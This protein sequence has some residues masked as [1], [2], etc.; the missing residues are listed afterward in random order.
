M[1]TVKEN[2]CCQEV[3]KIIEEIQEEMKLTDVKEIK[4]ITQHPGFASVCL[5]RHVL[6]TAYY[7]YRQDYGVNMPDNME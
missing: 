7:S 3:N 2:L 4:C 5:D 6:K 1:P